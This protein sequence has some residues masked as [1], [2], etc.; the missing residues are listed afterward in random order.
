MI[1]LQEVVECQELQ[2]KNPDLIFVKVGLM[3]L[4]GIAV[5]VKVF[6]ILLSVLD[7]ELRMLDVELKVLDVGLKMFD[8]YLLLIA[9]QVD[10]MDLLD[11]LICQ[12]VLETLAQ[13]L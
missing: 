3:I 9:F 8:S 2:P 5:G 1:P 7:P 11:K 13:K 10:E 4:Q 6:D 12:P